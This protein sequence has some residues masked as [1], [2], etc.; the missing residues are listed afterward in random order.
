M[1]ITQ[2][3][4]AA[5]TPADAQSAASRQP[6]VEEFLLTLAARLFIAAAIGLACALAYQRGWEPGISIAA[7]GLLWHFMGGAR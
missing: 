5:R 4:E 3:R 1:T 2:T 6:P 7:M